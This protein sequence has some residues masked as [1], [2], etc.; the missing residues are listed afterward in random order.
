MS[1][2]I[3]VAISVQVHFSQATRLCRGYDRHATTIQRKRSNH[4]GA[5][6]AGSSFRISKRGIQRVQQYSRTDCQED[7]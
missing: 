4:I 2:S 3:P 1:I 6:E 7:G 5:E